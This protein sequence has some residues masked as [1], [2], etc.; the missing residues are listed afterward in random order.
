MT[1][2]NNKTTTYAYDDADR[3]T[4]VTDAASQVTTYTDDTENNLTKIKDELLRETQ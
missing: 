1:D 4:S 2:A 3:L